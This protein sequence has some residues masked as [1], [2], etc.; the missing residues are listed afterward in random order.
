MFQVVGVPDPRLGEEICA[1]VQVHEGM[2][3]TEQELK[4]YCLQHV[5]II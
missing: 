4:D 5:S 2:K 3:C 1:C